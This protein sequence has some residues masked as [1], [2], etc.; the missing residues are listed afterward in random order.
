M[1]G[2]AQGPATAGSAQARKPALRSDPS[3]DQNSPRVAHTLTACSRCRQVCLPCRAYPRGCDTDSQQRKTRCDPGLPRCGPCERTNAV[4]EYWDPAKHRNINRD[5]VVWLQHRV[6]DLEIQL[7]KLENE[8]AQ[9]DPEVMVRSAAAVK[10]Q[11]NDETKFLGPSSG[12]Q[13]TRLVMQ[14]AKQ[15]TD[16]K[17]IKDI[18]PDY[19]A[20][21]VKELFAAESEKPTSKV[22]P[23]ISDVAAVDLPNREL[24]DLLLQLYN[25]KG[26]EF[27][28]S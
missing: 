17:T 8:D 27:T 2:S 5:Y 21:Q 1:N 10:L 26:E 19:K 20:R 14:L 23:L 13:I 28:A 3:D 7:D 11:D 6:R 24:T 16:S 12:T 22:Y 25:L 18:V 4:C 9:E 15:F